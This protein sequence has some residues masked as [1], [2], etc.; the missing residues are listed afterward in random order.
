MVARDGHH[1]DA[2]GV[3]LD[4]RLEDQTIGV[5]GDRPLVVHGGRNQHAI[6]FLFSGYIYDHTERLFEFTESRATPD[7]S[8]DVPVGGVQEAHSQSSLNLSKT[9]SVDAEAVTSSLL[10]AHEGKGNEICI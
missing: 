4:E 7:R 5:R 3:Q 9:S 2:S 8:P 6:D 1:R 10:V